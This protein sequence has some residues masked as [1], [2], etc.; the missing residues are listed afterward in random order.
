MKNSRRMARIF[1]LGL[2]GLMLLGVTGCAKAPAAIEGDDVIGAPEDSRQPVQTQSS[3]ADP[4]ATDDQGLDQLPQ[5]EEPDG[6][7]DPDEETPT[8]KMSY[9]ADYQNFKSQ[10]SDVI[11]WISVPNT[12]IEYPVLRTTDNNYYLHYNALKEQSKSGAIFMDYRNADFESSK[13]VI[14][15]GHNMRN[16]TMFHDLNSYKQK[17][18]F[19]NNP[20]ITLWVDGEKYEYEIFAAHVVLADINFI[21]TKFKSDEEF[22]DYFKEFKSYSKFHNDVEVEAGDQVL[23]LSTCTYEYD[24]SR[25]VVQAVRKQ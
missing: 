5:M 14:I 9:E 12:R 25:F 21:R 6:I 15:Y 2:A 4:S 17:D 23:T 13:H 7:P 1:A 11:G 3:E 10:N 24:D 19:E 8:E 16:A 22:V 20:V 18:F